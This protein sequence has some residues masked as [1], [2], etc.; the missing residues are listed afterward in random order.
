MKR[1]NMPECENPFIQHSELI[2]R[3]D[4]GAAQKLQRFVM[5]M[6]NGHAFPANLSGLRGLDERHFGIAMSLMRHYW[7]YGENDDAFMGLANEIR[8]KLRHEE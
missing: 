2:L 3:A 8:A 6:W 5:S 4:Y 7:L 1:K